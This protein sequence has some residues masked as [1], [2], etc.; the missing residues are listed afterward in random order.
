MDAIFETKAKNPHF[1][2]TQEMQL[3][4]VRAELVDAERKLREA[5]EKELPT[6]KLHDLVEENRNKLRQLI[7]K[8][9]G[10]NTKTF[11]PRFNLKFKGTKPRYRSGSG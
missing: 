1:T 3:E 5:N 4:A 7:K 2:S 6:G 11:F 10:L 9:E 8:F